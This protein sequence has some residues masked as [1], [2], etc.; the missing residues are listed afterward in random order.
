MTERDVWLK[1]ARLWDKPKKDTKG[2][3]YVTYRGAG[4]SY[5]ICDLLADLL[6]MGGSNDKLFPV[7][8]RKIEEL[9]D[10]DCRKTKAVGYKW[11]HTRSG[12]SERAK[13]CRKQA[14]MLRAKVKAQTA[15]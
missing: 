6:P 8:V 5:G 11:L 14:R 4:K 10:A 3:Y 12:A 9:E 1:A 13:F 15:H 7:M 2:Q